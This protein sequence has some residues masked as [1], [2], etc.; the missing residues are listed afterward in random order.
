ME[1]PEI[2][3]NHGIKAELR[4][5]DGRL[6][7]GFMTGGYSCCEQWTYYPIHELPPHGDLIGRDALLNRID[8]YVCGSMDCEFIKNEIIKAMPVI[9]PAERS[10]EDGN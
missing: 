6:E 5:I 1:M 2:K 9:V 3:N 4:R 7:L 10:G 8:A